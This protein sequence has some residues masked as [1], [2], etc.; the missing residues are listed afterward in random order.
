MRSSSRAIVRISFNSAGDARV[1][2]R[3]R[4][5]REGARM[6]DD[7]IACNGFS[8]LREIRKPAPV[9]YEKILDAA[10]LKA[11]LDFKMMNIFTMTGKAKMPRLDDPRVHGTHADLVRF[12]AGH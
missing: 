7:G 9:L 5:S 4:A 11:Q 1:G 6:R 3:F 12:I 2:E 8:K 10:M